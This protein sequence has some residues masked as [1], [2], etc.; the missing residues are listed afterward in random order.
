MLFLANKYQQ[1]GACKGAFEKI[2]WILKYEDFILKLNGEQVLINTVNKLLK[3]NG[4]SNEIIVKAKQII[5][6]SS[7]EEGLKKY[8][9]DYLERN[10]AKL[11]D[12]EKI[13]CSS[14]IIES[15]F[16]KF[17][18]S[19]SKSPNGAITE[20]CLSV[21]NYGKK[22]EIIEIKNAMEETRVV[23]IKKWRAENLPVSMQQKKRRLLKNAS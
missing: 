4:L 8:L 2:K 19:T 23:D 22:F 18:Y 12:L 7:V 10:K 20:G 16:G 14:D 9:L 17:K 1:T 13:I 5:N 21:A 11:P 3:N 6:Q 15:I